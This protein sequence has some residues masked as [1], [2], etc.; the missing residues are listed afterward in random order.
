MIS[1]VLVTLNPDMSENGQEALRAELTAAVGHQEVCQTMFEKGSSVFYFP[2][3]LISAQQG[4]F[5]FLGIMTIFLW[6]TLQ[7][8]LT[9]K[10]SYWSTQSIW[11]N[12]SRG[13]V[14]CYVCGGWLFLNV[15]RFKLT[16]KKTTMRL[17]HSVQKYIYTRLS[18]NRT[19][20]RM[21]I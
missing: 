17:K 8:D 15:W 3:S 12:S 18:L 21:T 13:R 5:S 9:S 6:W 14:F 20:V 11:G 16:S 10:P 2:P 1:I 4:L 7:Q 19:C